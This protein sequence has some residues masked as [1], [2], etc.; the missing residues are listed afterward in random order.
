MQLRRENIV[1]YAVK[2]NLDSLKEVHGFIVKM[3][4]FFL[5]F[6]SA[7]RHLKDK[8]SALANKVLYMHC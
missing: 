1:M 3:Y 8:L 6:M 4:Q 5:M 7:P 2:G